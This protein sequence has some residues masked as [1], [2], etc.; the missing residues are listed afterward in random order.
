MEIQKFTELMDL[1]ERL[2]D[3]PRHSWTSRGRRESVAEHSWR[4]A[5]MGI[6][7]KDEF[8]EIQ[9]EKLLKMCI[10]HDMGEAF[11]GDIPAFEKTK[12]DSLTEEQALSS[13]IETLPSPY[14]EE[15]GDLYQEMNCLETLEARVCKALD[16]MEALI[17]H[18]EADL[19]TWLPL[20]YELQLSYG[21]KE[22]QFSEYMK[23]LKKEVNQISLDKIHKSK[24]R[25]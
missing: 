15:F 19:S 22:V 16:K 13:W 18:N 4:L 3:T 11:T 10:L 1:A 2:K 25:R 23:T 9:M 12:Q 21:E 5:L 14:K 24:R 7:M 20:E 6:F 17:Q 8:P